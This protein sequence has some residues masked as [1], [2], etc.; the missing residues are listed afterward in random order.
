MANR[1]WWA[2]VAVIWLGQAAYSPAESQ[3]PVRLMSADYL[4]LRRH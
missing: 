3:Q 1:A 4:S 2:V